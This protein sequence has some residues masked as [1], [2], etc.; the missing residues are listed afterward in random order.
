MAVTE[1]LLNY[2]GMAG[3]TVMG[4]WAMYDI[5]ASGGDD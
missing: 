3:I 4:A 2:L 5:L 1:A